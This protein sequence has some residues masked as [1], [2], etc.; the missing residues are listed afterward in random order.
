MFL[1]TKKGGIMAKK[2]YSELAELIIKAVG[3]KSNISMLQHCVTR[4]RFNLK[5]ESIVDEATINSASGIMG[6]QFK[7][8]QYQV[9]IG[10]AVNDVY[11]TVCDKLGFEKEKAI[12]EV[13][14]EKAEKKKI[15]FSS[16]I[17]AIAGC[18]VPAIPLLA[19]AGLVKA[20][21]AL[22]LLFHVTTDTSAVYT[23]FYFASDSAFTFLPVIV[24]GFAAKKFKGNTGL[25]M[26]MGAMLMAP[27]F[28]SMV[29]AGESLKIL[30]YSIP[31]NSYSGTVFP[32]IITVFVMCK[33]EKFITKH[34]PDMFKYVIP[35][36]LTVLI[37]IPLSFGLL[38]P[39]GN[40]VGTYLAEFIMLIYNHLGFLGIGILT[41][42]TPFLIMTSMHTALIPFWINNFT[43]LGYEPI[44]DPS[45]YA[46]TFALAG[47]CIAKVVKSKD[48]EIKGLGI[49]ASVT[50][51][52]AAVTE[53]GLFGMAAKFKSTLISTMIGGFFGGCAM[54]LLGVKSYV[55][56]TGI[57]C[58]ISDGNNFL[59]A[60][61]S[62]AIAFAIS[63]A[64]GIILDGKFE[65][66]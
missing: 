30:G 49:S 48:K 33:L 50:A 4:L 27:T 28:V 8:G 41:A 62:L 12:D 44:C 40:F 47:A 39:I 2:D 55:M 65:N 61:I 53:P 37:M 56:T 32:A 14:D 9:I 60:M 5:D 31:M 19:G 20:V 23:L 63:F 24:G 26:L 7:A 21:L 66:K 38:A 11:D 35:P 18:I 15:S 54:G 22:L 1:G 17:D 13:I 3:G 10:G 16:F 52:V 57:L 59:Y 46:F 36:F 6:S 34:T 42:V 29:D 64:C 43:T 51:M 58:F 45:N 25:G